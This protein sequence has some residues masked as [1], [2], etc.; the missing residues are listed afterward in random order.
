[1]TESLVEYKTAVAVAKATVDAADKDSQDAFYT[2]LNKAYRDFLNRRKEE[3]GDNAYLIR[4]SSDAWTI[5]EYLRQEGLDWEADVQ[6]A[7]TWEPSILQWYIDLVNASF[8][9]LPPD[10]LPLPLP[11]PPPPTPSPPPPTPPPPAPPVLPSPP[12]PRLQHF[13]GTS[14]PDRLEQALQSKEEKPVGMW[15]MKKKA[16]KTPAEYEKRK[17]FLQ[18]KAQEALEKECD[19]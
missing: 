17:L 18:K 8:P 16:R 12:S 13:A 7:A 11:P 19:L 2:L 9:P 10:A 1:M 5:D 15:K 6:R 4:L 14:R 3:T